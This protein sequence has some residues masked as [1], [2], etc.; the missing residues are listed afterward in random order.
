[1]IVDCLW[2]FRG[3]PMADGTEIAAWYH[4]AALHIGGHWF[5][6]IAALGTRV[7]YVY[8]GFAPLASI[9]DWNGCFATGIYSPSAR[10]HIM[11]A[12]GTVYGHRRVSFM[13]LVLPVEVVFVSNIA[14]IKLSTRSSPALL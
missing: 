14:N 3:F 6:L 8:Y 1:M 13:M 9:G 7:S 4:Y 5:Q 12:F 2:L 11:S 10:K